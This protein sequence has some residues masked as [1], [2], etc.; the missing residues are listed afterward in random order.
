MKKVIIDNRYN[1]YIYYLYT[2]FISLF[3]IIEPI[4]YFYSLVLTQKGG[5]LIGKML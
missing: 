1:R 4:Y 2:I 3:L 5:N